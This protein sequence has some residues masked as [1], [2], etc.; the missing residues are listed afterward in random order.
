MSIWDKLSLASKIREILDVTSHDEGHHFGRPFLTPYQIAISFADSYP[1]ETNS[2]GK[3]IGGKGTG[4]HNSLAQYFAREL[5]TRIKNG[6]LTDIEGR[7]LHRQHLKKLQYD[8]RGEDID[9]SS[10]Q[11]YDL[12]MFRLSS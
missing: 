10:E 7:F 9:S 4:Q 8:S 1:D 2:I 6:E 12:S 5:S 11:A 3:P